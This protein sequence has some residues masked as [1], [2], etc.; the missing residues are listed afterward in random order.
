[1]GGGDRFHITHRYILNNDVRYMYSGY[2]EVMKYRGKDYADYPNFDMLR[3]N[4]ENATFKKNILKSFRANEEEE[5][6]FLMPR[7]P[8]FR[9]FSRHNVNGM[10]NRLMKPTIARVGVSSDNIDK[11]RCKEDIV[12]EDK[13]KS[14][15]SYRKLPEDRVKGIANRLL[16]QHTL[17]S[18]MKRRPKFDLTRDGKM[19]LFRQASIPLPMVG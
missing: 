13:S 16:R 11:L 6:E 7:M 15:S 3:I 10:V 19:T 8:A 2:P 14:Y 18:T 9:Y 5:D 12:E 4:R 1:M 17:M